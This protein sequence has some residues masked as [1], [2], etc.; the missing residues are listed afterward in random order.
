MTH[1]QLLMTPLPWHLYLMASLYFLAGLNHF[2]NPKI[3]LKI[4]PN[5][6]PNPKLLN[7]ISGGAEI[8]LATALCIPFLT[9]YAA[10]GIILLLVAVFP[11]NANMLLNKKAS[12]GLP[13]WL[14]LLRIPLQFL[15]IYWAF[16][17]TNFI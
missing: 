8:L 11:A 12:L 17:Y 2:R 10:I 9:H 6:L 14:L 15:L 7:N 3:Y 16:I 4:I 1:N 5:F 13:K